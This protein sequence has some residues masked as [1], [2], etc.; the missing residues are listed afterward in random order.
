[1]S[2]QQPI[3]R[4]SVSKIGTFTFMSYEPTDNARSTKAALGSP[5]GQESIRPSRPLLFG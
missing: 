1:M 5:M 4:F 2:G 3:Y